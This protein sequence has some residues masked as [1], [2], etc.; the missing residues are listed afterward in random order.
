[1][2][3]YGDDVVLRRAWRW[4]VAYWAVG[5]AV[6]LAAALWAWASGDRPTARAGLACFA[7]FAAVDAWAVVRLSRVEAA[8]RRRFDEAKRRTFDVHDATFRGLSERDREG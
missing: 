4:L 6:L 7:V 1:M 5:G 8:R 3:D 2:R